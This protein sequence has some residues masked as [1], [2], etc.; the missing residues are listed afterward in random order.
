MV[1]RHGVILSWAVIALL[2]STVAVAQ[3]SAESS[4]TLQTEATEQT[5]YNPTRSNQAQ[6]PM[7]LMHAASES[8]MVVYAGDQRLPS[9]WEAEA[10]GFSLWASLDLPARSAQ[11]VAIRPA[12]AASHEPA[13]ALA[14]TTDGNHL[15]LTNGLIAVR[16]PAQ[17]TAGAVPP[18]IASIRHGEG[19]WLGQ[20][21][22]QGVGELASYTVEVLGDGPVQL[23]LLQHFIFADDSSLRL[24]LR[25]RPGRDFIEIEEQ[26]QLPAAASWSFDLAAGDSNWQP[27]TSLFTQHGGGS[28][29]P[30]AVDVKTGT[31]KPGQTRMG[32]TLVHLL[33][34][35]SQAFDDGWLAAAS[36]GSH[37]VGAMVVRAGQWTWAHEVKIAAELDEN[38]KALR[39]RMPG[40][41]QV[42]E[43]SPVPSRRMW[44]LRS[45]PAETWSI[46]QTMGMVMNW[47]M[48]DL[49]KVNEHYILDGFDPKAKVSFPHP[50]QGDRVNPTGIWRQMAR[51]EF[52]KQVDKPAGYAD[53]IWAQAV[54]DPDFYGT[55]WYGWSVQNPNFWSDVLQRPALRIAR[56]H[57]HPRFAEL[58]KLA[59]LSLRSDLYHSV[60][61]PGGAGQE[62][63]G[64]QGHAL[65]VWEKVGK[66]TASRL[67]YDIRQWPR[68]LATKD[69]LRRISQPDGVGLRR[70]LPIGD[71]HPDRKGGTGPTVVDMAG[72]SV[73]NWQ[74]EEFPGYGVILRNNPGTDDETYVAFKAGPNRGHYHGDQLSLHWNAQ[75]RPLMV[76]HHASYAPRVGQEHM[77]N[78][79]SFGT[80]TMPW[81][82]IDGHERL[83][84]FATHPEVDIAHGQVQS[85][86]LR[87]TPK[88]P[89][90]EWDQRHDVEE[91]GGILTYDRSVIL[92]KGLAEDAVLLVDSWDAPQ[93][94]AVSFN[95]H[96]RGK[97][98]AENGSHISVD[99]RFTA[100]RILPEALPL[101][102]LDWSHENGGLEETVGLRWTQEAA[103]GRMITLLWPGRNPP[104]IITENTNKLSVGPYTIQLTAQGQGLPQVTV[105]KEGKEL[106]VMSADTDKSQGDIGL[107]VPDAGY[108]FG[109]IPQWLREE[110]LT[111]PAWAENLPITRSAGRI[112]ANVAARC[113]NLWNC[114]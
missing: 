71:T 2:S 85:T 17:V 62:C 42:G 53:Q 73:T 64:Y 45:A 33:P 67:G 61:L 24:R 13:S 91:F 101:E 36:D 102:R 26:I 103:Q 5:L 44:W 99:D 29:K 28:G 76:D 111:R 10:A 87:R 30:F 8:D 106:L 31:L 52:R 43:A 48:A 63:P 114:Q 51:N 96:V 86:R 55:P 109:P 70:M 4:A 90:E 88:L 100:L 27:Q 74:S 20:G 23:T 9:Q 77:H 11:T 75:A 89:P 93:P 46:K 18:P 69:F 65:H 97:E 60:A 39:L 66:A 32:D 113:F 22:W 54:L 3:E 81:A 21:A 82:T 105:T 59:E 72:A 49:N 16:I 98:V 12:D 41:S 40:H 37:A 56:L 110:R 95:A 1:F 78:R 57:G 58:N 50:Y 25:L 47:A 6:V 94:L 14:I 112:L 79:L 38:G 104:Q 35:W 107:F 7:R 108:P 19:P 15:V 83:L 34:R 68:Y 92:L 80:A 84:G